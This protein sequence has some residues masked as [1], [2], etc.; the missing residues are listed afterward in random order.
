MLDTARTL[1][2][3]LTEHAALKD[4]R[5]RERLTLLAQELGAE[6]VRREPIRARFIRPEREA[7]DA[8]AQAT[9]A[10]REAEEL[11]APPPEEAALLIDTKRAAAEQARQ[12]AVDRARRLHG[13]SNREPSTA[14]SRRDDPGLGM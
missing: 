7:R 3:A 2:A 8:H 13:A 5:D 14:Q 6:R 10:R 11:R 9:E 1:T 4:R 12:L